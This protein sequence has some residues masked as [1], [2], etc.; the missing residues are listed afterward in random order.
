MIPDVISNKNDVISTTTKSKLNG[1]YV[2]SQPTLKVDNSYVV[3]AS[4]RPK[5]EKPY[6]LNLHS[7]VDSLP[8]VG[9][10]KTSPTID[11]SRIDGNFGEKIL[12]KTEGQGF[13]FRPY[14]QNPLIKV[15]SAA[16]KDN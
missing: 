11:V 7:D 16:G 6:Q 12:E 3:T 15:K 14:R 5:L 1:A 4:P 8:L 13:E 2:F 10:F 9:V